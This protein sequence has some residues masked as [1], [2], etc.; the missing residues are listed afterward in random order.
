VLR[1]LV[2]ILRLDDI[3]VQSRFTGER[4]VPFIIPL[5]IP[6][7]V[8]ALPRASIRADARRPPSLRSLISVPHLIHSVNSRHDKAHR[9]P[10]H[11]LEQ[12]QPLPFEKW[13]ELVAS[14]VREH[15]QR[16]LTIPSNSVS[17]LP[18]FASS[19]TDAFINQLTD[20]K[21]AAIASRTA[22]AKSVSHCGLA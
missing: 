20:H 3:A 2:A 5:S 17:I 11:G 15:G 8:L 22:S 18:Q 19:R 10:T 12:L 4:Q 13:D 16:K 14:S 9:S 7:A 1:V 21:A 6:G